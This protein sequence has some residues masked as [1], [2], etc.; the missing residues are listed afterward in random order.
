MIDPTPG[1]FCPYLNA[2]SNSTFFSSLVKGSSIFP[3]LSYKTLAFK[4]QPIFICL[5]PTDHPTGS[6]NLF[7]PININRIAP[8]DPFSC[9]IN[10]QG[11]PNLPMEVLLLRDMFQDANNHH[12]QEHGHLSVDMLLNEAIRIR[13]IFAA[14]KT[15][16]NI[17]YPL[18]NRIFLN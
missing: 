9:K 11:I 13:S 8:N 16:S 1:S 14:L 5:S 2:K 15:Q 4:Y 18:S 17:E 7:Y 6:S 10:T 12:L 3:W